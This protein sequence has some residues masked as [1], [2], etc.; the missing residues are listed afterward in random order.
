MCVFAALPL[1]TGADKE[2]DTEDVSVR[3]D[4]RALCTMLYSVIWF[5]PEG[6]NKIPKH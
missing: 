5:M 3:A 1:E 6:M 4:V 2:L